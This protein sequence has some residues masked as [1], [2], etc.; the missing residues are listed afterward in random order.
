VI[1]SADG[2]EFIVG[3]D[4]VEKTGDAGLRRVVDARMRKLERE[5]RAARDAERISQGRAA[6]ERPDVV[7]ALALQPHPNAYWA[8]Q[9]QTLLD[10][11]RWLLE[12]AGNAGQMSAA[13]F[14]QHTAEALE[15][16]RTLVLPPCPIPDTQDTMPSERP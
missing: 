12:H 3:T 13:R 5:R 15:L 11:V 8:A 14:V 1:R 16:G 2:R 9:G 7:A 6:L 10:R 4:C